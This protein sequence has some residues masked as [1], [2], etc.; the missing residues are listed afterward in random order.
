MLI[1]EFD[2]EAAENE[3]VLREVRENNMLSFE[4]DLNSCKHPIMHEELHYYATCQKMNYPCCEWQHLKPSVK[5]MASMFQEGGK[6]HRLR[7]L[8]PLLTVVP[9]SR[10]VKS[11]KENPG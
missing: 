2:C 8:F 6:S 7:A 1:S 4:Q 11:S 9:V 3:Y 5:N 10:S